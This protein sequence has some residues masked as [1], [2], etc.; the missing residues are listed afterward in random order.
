MSVEYTQANTDER[1]CRLS[2]LFIKKLPDFLLRIV[3]KRFLVK[4]SAKTLS[5]ICLLSPIAD[6]STKIAFI[7]TW[8]HLWELFQIQ[9][10][11]Y[12]NQQII[13]FRITFSFYT[14]HIACYFHSH[15][16]SIPG[17]Y[18]CLHLRRTRESYAAGL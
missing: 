1:C 9:N 5:S 13:T 14:A 17:R 4:D 15:H 11:I 8:Q 2:F 16:P 7:S 3:R 10:I 6:N 12:S 18:H